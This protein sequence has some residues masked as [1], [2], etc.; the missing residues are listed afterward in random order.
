M[1][2]HHIGIIVD[3]IAGETEIYKQLGYEAYGVVTEDPI[4]RLRLLFMK[5]CLSG[6]L[7]ELIE[8]IDEKSTV[9]NLPKGYV[10]ICYEVPDLDEFVQYFK[11]N[12]LGIIFTKKLSAPALEGRLIVFAYLKNRTIVEF[13][14]VNKNAV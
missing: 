3:S 11:K 9:H 7:I 5:N 1:R 4:Q 14:E 10:H 12:K 6:E 2:M 13:V 8:S